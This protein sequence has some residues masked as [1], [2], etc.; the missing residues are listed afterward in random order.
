MRT[1]LTE[2][3]I[4]GPP[5]NLEFLAKILLDDGFVAGNNLTRFL[6]DF[7]FTSSA[8]DVVSGGAY[9]LI[10]DWPGRPTLGRGFCH[11][12]MDPVAFR[13]A[14]ALVGNPAGLETLEITLSGPDL[15]FLGPAIVSLCEAPM[16]ARLDGVPISMWSRIKVSA[17]QRLAIGRTTGGGCRA[18]YHKSRPSYSFC[19]SENHKDHH[20]HSLEKKDL[21]IHVTYL[22]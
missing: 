6:D 8:I 16:D 10:E 4:C 17:G 3:R 18:I 22:S 7:Q 11:W 14:N 1:I 12:P 9:T 13:I 19:T 5:T 15:C 21:H 2:S 20:Q